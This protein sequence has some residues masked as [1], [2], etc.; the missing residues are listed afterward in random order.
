MLVM[1]EGKETKGD[2][3]KCDSRREMKHCIEGGGHEY[4]VG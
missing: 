4:I 1:V 3:R 2:G